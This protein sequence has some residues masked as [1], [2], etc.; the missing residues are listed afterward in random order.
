MYE[1]TRQEN[2]V[3]NIKCNICDAIYVGEERRTAKQIMGEHQ[4]A[5]EKPHIQTLAGN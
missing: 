5:E 4:R 3:Y 1:T 2:A